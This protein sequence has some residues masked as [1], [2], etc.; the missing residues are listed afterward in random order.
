MDRHSHSFY[1]NRSSTQIS[2]G[3]TL[4]TVG[5]YAADPVS[6]TYGS[7]RVFAYTTQTYYKYI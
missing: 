2:L 4:V 6:A 3:L 1:A 7:C 5:I